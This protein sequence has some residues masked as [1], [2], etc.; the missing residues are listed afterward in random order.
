MPYKDRAVALL[1]KREWSHA[2]PNHKRNLVLKAETDRKYALEHKEAR[3]ESGKRFRA[4]HKDELRIYFR[5]YNKKHKCW[6]RYYH[7]PTGR[8][9][10]LFSQQL[11]HSRKRNLPTTLTLEEWEDIKKQFE[12]KCAYCGQP[13]KLTQ[14]HF[15][16]VSKGGGLTKENIVPACLSCNGRKIDKLVEIGCWLSSPFS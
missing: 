16:P 4:N 1:K 12:Y 6:N 14:D 15:I 3:A 11:Y 13:R 9:K 5:E 8:E 7:T 10:I 2:H